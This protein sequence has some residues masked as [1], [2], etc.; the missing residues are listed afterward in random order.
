MVCLQHLKVAIVSPV[1]M[2]IEML[3]PTRIHVSQTMVGII[4]MHHSH[5]P[6]VS[7]CKRLDKLQIY[8]VNVLQLNAE[9]N[10]GSPAGNRILALQP[11]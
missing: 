1:K 2:G 8:P 3:N 9:G 4:L 6:R 7:S 11:E 5:F 10:S